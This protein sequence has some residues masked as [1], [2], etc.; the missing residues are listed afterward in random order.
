MIKKLKKAFTI[1]EL[2]IVIAVIAILAAVL[3][4]TFS[5]VIESANKS[6]ALQTSN[7]ALKEYLA[8]VG[9]D[10]DTSNDN[11]VGM[12]F[13]NDGYA[14]VYLN[15]A[16][17]YIGKTDDLAYLSVST[18]DT[19]VVLNG[20]L[21]S[22]ITGASETY[23]TGD[24]IVFTITTKAA[25]GDSAAETKEVTIPI[26]QL[27]AGADVGDAVL[28]EE[29]TQ[30]KAEEYIYFYSVSNNNTNYYGFFT[31]ERGNSSRFQ[32][33]G[34]TYSRRAGYSSIALGFDVETPST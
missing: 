19:Q 18:T 29:I 12:V 32:V 7:N 22:S 20:S 3:I 4:P 9:T 6:A 24:N 23:Q 33:E 27:A 2:V 26:A 28:D 30:A 11:P 25:E 34:A 5:N 15:G 1:T 16:L 17:Q 10:D 14:Y 13:V 8:V 21:P 31:L